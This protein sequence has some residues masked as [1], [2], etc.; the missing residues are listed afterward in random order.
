MEYILN[1]L[2]I[3]DFSSV[4]YYF[5]INGKETFRTCFGGLSYL[6]YFAFLFYFIIKVFSS[7]IS[8]N[9]FQIISNEKILQS[10][11]ELKLD[12][13]NLNFIF[14]LSYDNKT[15]LPK[16]IINKY[17]VE[18]LYFVSM[19]NSTKKEKIELNFTQ[20]QE[21]DLIN[22]YNKDDDFFRY[23]KYLN[24]RC[25]DILNYSLKGSFNDELF[26]YLE[27]GIYLNWKNILSDKIDLHK[28][29][30]TENLIKIVVKYFELSFDFDNKDFPIQSYENNVFDYLNFNLIKK[31][32]LDYSQFIYQNDNN[33][34]FENPI[35]E[36]YIK[37][38][39]V[40]KYFYQMDVRTKSI[41]DYD[42]LFKF[43]I[44][45]SPHYFVFNRIYQ[46]LPEML[47]NITGLSSN[48]LV[49]VV[50]LNTFYNKFKSKEAL[51]NHLL[52]FKDNYLVDLEKMEKVDK[53]NNYYMQNFKNKKKRVNNLEEE[54]KIINKFRDDETKIGKNN[55]KRMFTYK[56]K[57]NQKPSKDNQHLKE[58]KFLPKK[59]KNEKNLIKYGIIKEK[60]QKDI[61]NDF[62][63][64]QE[65]KVQNVNIFDKCILI[66]NDGDLNK[67][68]YETNNLIE[69][70]NINI[71]KENALILIKP[72]LSSPNNVQKDILL[73]EVSFSGETNV[74]IKRDSV[75]DVAILKQDANK[76]FLV[77]SNFETIKDSI[78]NIDRVTFFPNGYK[79][80]TKN[81]SIDK[82]VN[83]K[84]HISNNNED[85]LNIKAR[86]KNEIESSQKNLNKISKSNDSI[87]QI[88]IQDIENQ[89]TSGNL[90]QHLEEKSL[91]KES[92]E[93]KTKYNIKNVIVEE[94]D[95]Q[96]QAS[97]YD[98][99]LEKTN[100][101]KIVKIEESKQAENLEINKKENPNQEDLV[102]KNLKSCK[103]FKKLCKNYILNENEN[104]KTKSIKLKNQGKILDIINPK[105]LGIRK[106]ETTFRIL[107][108]DQKQEK[109]R[110]KNKLKKPIYFNFNFFEICFRPLCALFRCRKKKYELYD[111]SFQNINNHLNIF[112]Y[113]KLIQEIEIIKTLTFNEFQ[114]GIINFISKP[115]M[116]HDLNF[117]IPEAKD[118][119]EMFDQELDL[120]NVLAAYENILQVNLNNIDYKLIEL[121]RFELKT[122]T[123]KD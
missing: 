20:C 86:E 36:K 75:H 95:N 73:S 121:L 76:Y 54:N 5:H 16:E 49:F 29:F 82:E 7:F 58:E 117:N 66:N 27:Y 11:P 40:D 97:K 30:F 115:M 99:N 8:K 6:S 108:K 102:V 69:N 68:I 37:L 10:P 41:S 1:C 100:C 63:N 64:D 109:I 120:G 31:A 67:N 84:N 110:I 51:V 33:I 14:G 26:Q 13:Y 122:L 65:L 104:N 103:F 15:D 46:K 44:R 53:L 72:D 98:T 78:I 25:I 113:L 34:L 4:N 85:L 48:L 114:I 55:I 38:F 80:L 57:S 45:S 87:C 23:K 92:N 118:L 79:N 123:K 71:N 70:G 119:E 39:A 107:D 2:K 19:T 50:L 94:Q 116:S 24:F 3:L 93:F 106:F 105:K 17:I 112:F 56:D 32:N 111:K 91:K 74:F 21:K 35:S 42:L 12:D 60:G 77:N 22:K 88:Y 96:E 18:K 9:K 52:K 62:L 43:Y 61:S 59:S 101:E 28:K 90:T 83:I 81:N 89:K 47:A